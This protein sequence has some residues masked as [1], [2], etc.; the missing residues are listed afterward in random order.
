MCIMYTSGSTGPPKGVMITHSNLVASIGAAYMLLGHH[1]TYEDTYLAYLPLAHVL[2]YI[3]KLIILFVGM[4]TGYG[5]VKTLTSASV[6]KC[7]GDLEAFKPSIMVS[8]PAVRETIWKAAVTYV[9]LFFS[10][11]FFFPVFVL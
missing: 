11:S 4:T 7:L 5:R 8:V 2:E 1:L 3:V 9:P 10:F 6:Q